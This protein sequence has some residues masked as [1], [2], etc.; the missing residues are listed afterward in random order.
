M[1]A[2]LPAAPD[3]PETP[4]LPDLPEPLG[5]DH[6]DVPDVAAGESADPE[7]DADLTPDN[8]AVRAT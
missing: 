8:P 2:D 1:T 6:V 5:S 4:A 3:L 7:P